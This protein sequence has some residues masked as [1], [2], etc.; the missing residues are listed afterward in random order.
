MQIFVILS[1][2]A[3]WAIYRS[4]SIT[5]DR[6]NPVPVSPDQ[7]DY[8]NLTFP[9]CFIYAERRE[10]LLPDEQWELEQRKEEPKPEQEPGLPETGAEGAALAA[11][12]QDFRDLSWQDA[13]KAIRAGIEDP[14]LLEMIRTHDDRASVQRA[15]DD[16]DNQED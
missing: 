2:A 14:D 16:L 12:Y 7:V 10:D 4:S 3:P 8:L 5:V 9:G 6:D 11:A 13:V 1:G 15:L